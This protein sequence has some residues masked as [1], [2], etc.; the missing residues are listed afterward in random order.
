L[1]W[2]PSALYWA[3]I[4]ERMLSLGPWP[5]IVLTKVD[6]PAI[7]VSIALFVCFALEDLTKRVIRVVLDELAVV[8]DTLE[9]QG[10]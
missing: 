6:R 10:C 3:K 5:V 8:A 4:S 7:A 9:V 2:P 1:P